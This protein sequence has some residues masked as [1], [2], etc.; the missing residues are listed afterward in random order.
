MTT[1]E[2]DLTE[3]AFV[4]SEP[5][6]NGDD[7]AAREFQFAMRGYSRDEVRDFLRHIA[8]EIDDRDGRI[9]ELLT[10][11]ERL[12]QRAQAFRDRF[13]IERDRLLAD[14]A[15]KDDRL[16]ELES[17]MER[18]ESERLMKAYGTEIARVLEEAE[19]TANK[20]RT[21]AENEARSRTEDARREAEEVRTSA[22]NTAERL[23]ADAKKQA[24]DQIGAATTE[25]EDITRL[26]HEDADDVRAR[27]KLL[28]GKLAASKSVLD[29]LVQR[30]DD[31]V[32]DA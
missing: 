30:V 28:I 2:I 23:T 32:S 12:E 25:G 4:E 7:V 1:S 15:K 27:T 10:Q 9:A 24:K 16:A 19:T 5:Y 20:L 13:V 3:P 11:V 6:L 14:M 31:E 17:E 18:P 26:A 8:D 22:L 29:D 21:A